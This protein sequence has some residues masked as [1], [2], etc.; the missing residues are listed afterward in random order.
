MLSEPILVV[1][2]VIVINIKRGG[3][4]TRKVFQQICLRL[5]LCLT[6]T[7]NKLHRQV[8][9][10]RA[11]THPMA[12]TTLKLQPNHGRFTDTHTTFR[13]CRVSIRQR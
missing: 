3:G 12:V 7:E 13:A 4:R 8:F 5:W 2:Q 11:F 6:T 1:Q 10:V 9:M